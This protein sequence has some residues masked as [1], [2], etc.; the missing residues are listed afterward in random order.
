MGDK[1]DISGFP[2]KAD[3]VT[4]HRSR[5]NS[6]GCTQDDGTKCSKQTS[7]QRMFLQDVFGF[8]AGIKATMVMS[9]SCSRSPL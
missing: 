4:I 7:R 2:I 6:R 9:S 8:T 1:M 3:H 5:K